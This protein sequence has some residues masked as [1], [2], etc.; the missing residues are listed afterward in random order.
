M[1]Y[2]SYIFLFILIQGCASVGAGIDVVRNV[3]STAID[4]TV[5]AGATI[6]K[7][8]AEDVVET[9]TFI[10]EQGTDI[11]ANAAEKVDEETDRLAVPGVDFP[12]G[13]LKE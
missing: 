12:T 13:E 1:K 11:V 9:G 3:A 4:T 8:V 5:Q 7:A 6:T 10:D 2:L